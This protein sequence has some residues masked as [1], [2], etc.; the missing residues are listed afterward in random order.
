MSE[1]D[2]IEKQVLCSTMVWGLQNEVLFVPFVVSVVSRG[3]S[4]CHCIAEGPPRMISV[5]EP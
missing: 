4:V 5:V 1:G 3:R 2:S